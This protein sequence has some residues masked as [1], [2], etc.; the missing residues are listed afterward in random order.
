L[1][2]VYHPIDLNTESTK[3]FNFNE[4]KENKRIFHVGWWLRNF[5]TFIEFK[6]PKKYKKII[7][8]KNEFK[9]HF[10]KKFKNI[11][12]SIKINCELDDNEYVKIFNNSCI[13]CDLYDCVANNLVL[14]CI[15][16]NTPIIIKR[17]PALEEYL[18][19]DYPLF[20]DNTEDLV[21]YSDEK[22]LLLKIIE[23]NVY[24][25]KMDKTPFMLKT[26]CNKLTYDINKLKI[27]ND[28]CKL[29]WLYYLND[30]NIDIKK[31]ISIFNQQHNR[32]NIKLIIVN[33]ISSKIELLE[34]NKSDNISIINIDNNLNMYEIYNIFIENSTTEYL[35]FKRF[36]EFLN[37]KIRSNSFHT[38]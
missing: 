7:L 4:F 24:L 26:F 35:I 3:T 37:N 6:T 32:E 8:V 22:T 12:N 5:N 18:G 9:E 1:V 13:F 11:N 19:I 38:I 36:N 17:L 20:F 2:S 14:E 28:S 15:K 23:A 31:Y 21:Q 34:K 16:Y 27:K 25:Q 29:T 30:E 33:S 10:Y